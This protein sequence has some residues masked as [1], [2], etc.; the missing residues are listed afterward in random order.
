MANGS[1]YDL[2][3]DHMSGFVLQDE[4]TLRQVIGGR[5]IEVRIKVKGKLIETNADVDNATF[6]FVPEPSWREMEMLLLPGESKTSLA[7]LKSG[8]FDLKSV[9]GESVGLKSL[10]GQ[11]V[12]LD[13]WAT[14]CPP[15][16]KEL[17]VIDKLQ[18][19][20]IG[21]VRFFGVNDE[22]SSTVKSYLKKNQNGLPTLMDTK[23]TVHKQYGVDA[24]PTVLVIDREGII[25]SQF[26]GGRTEETL[27]SAITAALN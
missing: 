15:C 25:R 3:V 5:E 22:D 7:G 10:R 20:F 9:E 4:E 18:A 24:I 16:R 13:F 23:R 27:R 11:V 19:E 26:V 8:D 2:W 12:V 1:T 6:E 17:P 14:W 21:K